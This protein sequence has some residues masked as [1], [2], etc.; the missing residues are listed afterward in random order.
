MF[1]TTEG[2]WCLIV[3]P[4]CSQGMRIKEKSHKPILSSY[5]GAGSVAQWSSLTQAI[6][7]MTVHID[8]ELDGPYVKLCGIS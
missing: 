5:A 1:R 6:L 8:L 2:L 7:D 4:V 3:E